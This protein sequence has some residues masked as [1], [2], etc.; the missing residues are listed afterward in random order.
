M[1]RHDDDRI[2]A[3]V[4]R[5]ASNVAARLK[6]PRDVVA[7]EVCR[8]SG[9]LR[10]PGCRHAAWVNATGEVTY[11][12]MVYTD[13]FVRGSETQHVCTDHAAEYLPYQEPVFSAT[14]F[15]GLGG[16]LGVDP[17]VASPPAPPRDPAMPVVPAAEL[18]EA[19]L[20]APAPAEAAPPGP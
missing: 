3:R 15:D 1:A 11:K 7:V 12:S 2:A 19:A 16:I 14:A 17:A 9:S 18:P 8:I 5:E 4:S 6:T 13:Y 10:D 20:P